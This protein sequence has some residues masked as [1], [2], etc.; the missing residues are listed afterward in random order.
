VFS[1]TIFT[2]YN[3]LGAYSAYDWYGYI[4]LSAGEAVTAQS[5]FSASNLVVILEGEEGVA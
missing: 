3:I 2:L 1:G 4:V 5:I